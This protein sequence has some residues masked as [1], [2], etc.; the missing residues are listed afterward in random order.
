M[1]KGKATVEQVCSECHD[2]GVMEGQKRSREAWQ[3]L[4]DDMIGRGA[5]ASEAQEA[6]L[7]DYLAAAYPADQLGQTRPPESPLGTDRHPVQG[8]AQ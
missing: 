6:L 8:G 1:A 7:I 3:Q 4:V 5:K 2:S